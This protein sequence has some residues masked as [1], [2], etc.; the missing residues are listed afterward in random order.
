MARKKYHVVFG[1]KDSTWKVKHG[2]QIVHTGSKKADVLNEAKTLAKQH[3]KS[4]VIVHGKDGVIQNEYTDGDD[5]KKS[6]G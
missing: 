5:P 1:K 4:Q 6:K 3:E 2:G